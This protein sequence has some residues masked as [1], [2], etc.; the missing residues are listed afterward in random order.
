MPHHAHGPWSVLTV[1]AAALLPQVSSAATITSCT[2]NDAPAAYN[3]STCNQGKTYDV[4]YVSG[5]DLI[6]DLKRNGDTSPGIGHV[7]TEYNGTGQEFSAWGYGGENTKFCCAISVSANELDEVKLWGTTYATG[8]LG[9]TLTF[10]DTLGELGQPSNY[11]TTTVWG[12]IG[13]QEGE[14]VILGSNQYA[15]YTEDLDGGDDADQ[16]YGNDAQDH[17]YAGDGDDIVDGGEG[18][19]WIW[20][21]EGVDDIEGGVGNDIIQGNAGA[22]IIYGGDDDDEIYGGTG[23][24]YIDGEA[25]VD[26]LYGEADIDEIHGGDDEDTIDGGSEDDDLWGGNHSDTIKGGTGD[27]VIHG[28]GGDDFINGDGGNDTIYGGLG[29]NVMCGGG[30]SGLGHD[31]FYGESGNDTMWEPFFA[32][33]PTGTDTGGVDVCGHTIHGSFLTSGTC[34]YT[35]T[36]APLGCP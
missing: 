5:N 10:W 20:G 4:C 27:D 26:E 16:I 29:T 3:T 2:S 32:N 36:S 30:T 13:G 28:V 33:A 25:G 22:D 11:T 19:D 15:Y 1:F 14:D 12:Q 24:D 17:I 18:T 35:L 21:E 9:D 34:S 23:D 31:A 8:G 7:V 6:C